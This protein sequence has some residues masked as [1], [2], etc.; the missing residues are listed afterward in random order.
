M[1]EGSELEDSESEDE[2]DLMDF[3]R[4][5][6]L[7]QFS[8]LSFSSWLSNAE[9]SHDGEGSQNGEEQQQEESD[10]D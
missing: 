9:D 10:N 4:A 7:D 6:S 5:M 2:P 8:P 3:V 1:E